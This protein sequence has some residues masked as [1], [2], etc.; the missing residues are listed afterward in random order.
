MPATEPEPVDPV[1]PI[2]INSPLFLMS[3]SSPRR[4]RGH[5]DRDEDQEEDLG[6]VAGQEGGD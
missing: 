1:G 6:D 2:W 4:G 5:Q 3:E